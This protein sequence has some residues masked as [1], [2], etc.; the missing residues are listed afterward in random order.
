M[1]DEIRAIA[2]H[3]PQYHPIP[4][5]DK[6]WGMGF[7]EWTNVTK[8]RPLFKGHYQPQ[9]PTD[10]G[11]YDLRLAE[12]RLQQAMLAREYGI[13]GFCYYHYWFNGER[14]L[15][16]PIDGML[17]QEE[18]DHPFM[19]CW[20]NENWTR[21]WDGQN[22][23]VLKQQTYSNDDDLEHIRWLCEQVF[24]DKR[25]IKI[26]GR[27]VFMIYRHDLFPDINQTSDL[28]N[29]VAQDEYGFPGLYLINVQ[30]FLD[31]TSPA[32]L[33][34]DAAV[35]FSPHEVLQIPFK[36]KKRWWSLTSSDEPVIPSHLDARDFKLG[37]QKCL[38]R[39]SPEYKLYRCVTPAWDNTARK[40]EKALIG[41]GSSP[42][43]YG[44][45]L[46]ETV[47]S[48]TPFSS[49]EN[50][51]FINAW[52][53]WAEGNHLEPC[54]KYGRAFLEATRDALGKVH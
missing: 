50:F 10:L 2:F 1:M 5:N 15:N 22:N 47:N 34:L 45:W 16:K 33:G 14:L 49:E 52:N 18:M 48:F 17:A 39:K 13:H 28:W 29:R 6:W 3:L 25:Y 31:R 32:R 44:K 51:V 42:E 40:G 43:L 26:N 46:R 20:A 7:T 4:E 21:A 8:A 11:F 54:I 27:P 19:L 53:E 37:V 38:S 9:L 12:A 41:V 35:E 36:K 30:S 24:S 23:Q